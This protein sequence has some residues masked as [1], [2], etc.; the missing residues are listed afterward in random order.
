MEAE[1]IG[2]ESNLKALADISLNF[3]AVEAPFTDYVVFLSDFM[4]KIPLFL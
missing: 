3:G 2:D 4:K 1:T